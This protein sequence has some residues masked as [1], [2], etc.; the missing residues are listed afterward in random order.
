MYR[1]LLE[2]SDAMSAGGTFPSSLDALEQRYSIQIPDLREAITRGL[3]NMA[4]TKKL[5][6]TA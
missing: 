4:K 1:R 2:L 5:P 6:V 3:E